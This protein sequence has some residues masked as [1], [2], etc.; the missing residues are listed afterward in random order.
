MNQR[1][2]KTEY[3]FYSNEVKPDTER[4]SVMQETGSNSSVTSGMIQALKR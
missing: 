2:K 3:H 4:F 1:E